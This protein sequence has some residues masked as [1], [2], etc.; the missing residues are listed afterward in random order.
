MKAHTK[1]AIIFFA[2]NASA[3]LASENKNTCLKHLGGGMSDVHCYMDLTKENNDKILTTSK[4]ILNTMPK[5][6]KYIKILKK[7]LLDRNN[8]NEYCKLAKGAQ[9]NWG[10]YDSMPGAKFNEGDVDYYSCI[11][12]IS[13]SH[14]NFLNKI[15]ESATEP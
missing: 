2:F 7:Y 15:L 1:I 5:N 14:L 8:I 10:I 12:E 9:N 3:I 13:S 6:S 11:Y 4:K